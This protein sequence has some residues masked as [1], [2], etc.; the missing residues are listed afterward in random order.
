MKWLE[1]IELRTG[2]NDDQELQNVFRQLV[3]ELR[4]DPEYPKIKVYHN[5]AVDCDYSI[6]L[7]HHQ[8]RPEERGSALGMRIAAILK[9][10]GLVSHNTWIEQKNMLRQAKHIQK[11]K[12]I[13]SNENE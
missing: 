6:H 2:S 5:Y 9:T 13:T 3:K 7:A 1:I 4:L 10:F 8:F 12:H 11:D